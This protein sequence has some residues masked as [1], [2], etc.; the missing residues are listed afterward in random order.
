M[1]LLTIE[2][3]T[4]VLLKH[5]KFTLSLTFPKNPEVSFLIISKKEI[6]F[7]SRVYQNLPSYF[8]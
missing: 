6:D 3:F 7:S 1:Y 5:L 8:M 4:C 2:M